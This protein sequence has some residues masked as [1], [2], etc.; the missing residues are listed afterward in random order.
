MQNDCAERILRAL[1]NAADSQSDAS[2]LL[3]AGRGHVT[4]SNRPFTATRWAQFTP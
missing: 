2:I 1:V 4:D 3:P